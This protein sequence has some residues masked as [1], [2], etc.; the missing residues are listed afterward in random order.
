MDVTGLNFGIQAIATDI[1]DV[2]T[3]LGV[4]ASV[5][6]GDPLVTLIEFGNQGTVTAEGVGYVVNVPQGL[7]NVSCD[8]V[9]CTYDPDGVLTFSGLPTSLIP[10]QNLLLKVTYTAPDTEP[11]TTSL[12][13]D[14][15]ISTTTPGDP[16]GNNSDSGTTL[17]SVSVVD[18][19]AYLSVPPGALAASTVDVNVTYTNIGGTQANGVSYS[20]TLS[21]GLSDVTCSGS[22]VSCS[23]DNGTGMVTVSGLPTALAPSQSTGFILSYT[24]PGSD[25]VDVSTTIVASDDSYAPNNSAGGSTEIL[26]SA[27]APDLISTVAPPA[28][29]APG[30]TVTVPV[31]YQNLGPRPGDRHPLGSDLEG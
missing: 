26:S 5:A 19:A 8:G 11:P 24:A 3:T 10:G 16:P 31:V 4:P 2:Y 22:G 7:S 21:P 27:S 17:V 30:S 25:P 9:T 29:A 13:A 28:S 23:Y 12:S 14:A 6:I 1:P 20:L 18:V 15:T